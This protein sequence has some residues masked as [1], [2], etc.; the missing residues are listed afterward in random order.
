[1]EYIIFHFH[2]ISSLELACG[3]VD[4]SGDFFILSQLVLS[5]SMPLI[6]KGVSSNVQVSVYV[7]PNTPNDLVLENV[8]APVVPGPQAGAAEWDYNGNLFVR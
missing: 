6:L 1:M 5:L 8:S 3:L 2:L 4:E 7:I